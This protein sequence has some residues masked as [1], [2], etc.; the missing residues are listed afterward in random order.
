MKVTA[1]GNVDSK[2]LRSAI[3]GGTAAVTS[4]VANNNKKTSSKNLDKD[5]GIWG[6]VSSAEFQ[7]SQNISRANELIIGPNN[8][9]TIIAGSSGVGKDALLR[10]FL[11]KHPDYKLSVSHT[12]RKQRPGEI[13]GK[14]YYFV[15]D[16]D[17]HFGIENGEFLEWVDFAGNKYGTKI[18]VLNQLLKKTNNVI[19]KLDTVGALKVK[20]LIPQAKLI[21]IAPPSYEVLEERLKGRGTESKKDIR[22]RLK[23]A[24]FEKK[25]SEKFDHIIINDDL[26]K[27]VEDTE[28]ILCTNKDN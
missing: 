8:T 27:A 11:E 3:A 20:E 13:N 26:D 16:E 18:A 10:K 25:N 24:E 28:N 5:F 14:D 23:V 7:A 1:P 19:L 9:I 22:N 6:R 2:I 21:F 17:F 15:N 4:L 12:T